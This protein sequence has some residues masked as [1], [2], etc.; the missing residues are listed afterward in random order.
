MREY[1]NMNNAISQLNKF[2][3]NMK[4]NRL[5]TSEIRANKIRNLR[6]NMIN[7]QNKMQNSPVEY[8]DAKK[9]YYTES[10]GTTYYSNIQRKKF[11]SEANSQVNR[12]NKD[13][14]NNLFDSISRSIPFYKSQI[15]YKKNVDDVYDSYDNKIKNIK[16]KINDTEQIKNVN[17]RLGEFY[18]NNTEIVDWWKFY[19]KIIYYILL[20]FSVVIFITKSQY[21]KSRMY[22][23]FVTMFIFPFILE[24]YYNAI[25]RTFRHF[26]LDNIYFIFLLTIFT[27]IG[28]LSF[29]SQF[30]FNN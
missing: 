16:K 3:Q 7:A 17:Q 26:K 25:M 8:E 21:K 29:V 2:Q 30:P 5:T 23:F 19:L 9:Q 15:L 22:L 11:E 18:Y 4:S 1:F 27:I 28:I 6:N 12:W 20:V 14:V 13:Y 24:K 10:R